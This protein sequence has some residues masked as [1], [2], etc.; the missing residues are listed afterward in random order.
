MLIALLGRTSVHKLIFSTVY[1]VGA[2]IAI[3]ATIVLASGRTF[4]WANAS[5]TAGLATVVLTIIGLAP[6]YSH[7]STLHVAQ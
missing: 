1:A 3:E 5:V 2:G 4:D 7:P 6:L